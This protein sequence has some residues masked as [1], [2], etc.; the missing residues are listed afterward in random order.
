MGLS[1]AV[2]GEQTAGLPGLCLTCGQ[3]TACTISLISIDSQAVSVTRYLD[4][5]SGNRVYGE[6]SYPR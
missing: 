5:C 6:I 3:D 4:L 1:S 2:I